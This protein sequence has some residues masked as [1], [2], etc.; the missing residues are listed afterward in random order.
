MSDRETIS[1]VRT[2]FLN[3]FNE[4][5]VEAMAACVTDEVVGMP[6]NQPALRGK[7][8][9]RQFWREGFTVARSQLA[10]T[11]EDLVIDGDVAIDQFRWSMDSTPRTGGTM[12]HDEGKC[13]WIWYRQP[14]GSWKMTRAI[15]NSDLA[16]AGLWSGARVAESA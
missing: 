9:Q 2:E 14:E 1:R 7:D 8:A 10:V 13:I 12:V 5:N 15:W 6:P 4:E 16:T 3:A 11:P